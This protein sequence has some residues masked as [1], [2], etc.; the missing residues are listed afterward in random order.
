MV[1]T[2]GSSNYSKIAAVQLTTGNS[3]AVYPTLWRKGTVLN[4]SN[5]NNEK[6]TA[7]FFTSTGR[8]VGISTT[9]NS[10][11]PTNTL[12]NQSGIIYYKV[13]NTNGQQI[14]TGNLM[15]N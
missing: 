12:N 6:L 9:I 15:V 2:D 1:E 8:H 3:I 13:V 4:I 5:P 11:L 14:G 7:W 10:T